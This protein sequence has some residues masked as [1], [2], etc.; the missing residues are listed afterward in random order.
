MTK[1]YR[2]PLILGLLFMIGLG[3]FVWVFKALTSGSEPVIL[4]ASARG[5]ELILNIPERI[6]VNEPFQLIIRV[7]T[8]NERV[9]AAGIYLSFDPHMLQVLQQ[10]TRSSF[11]Q[12]YP[13]K[14][15]DNR[16][17]TVSLAC[18]SPHPGFSGSNTLMILEFMPLKVG[19]SVIR[20]SQQ[21]QILKSDGKGTN[22]LSAYPMVEIKAGNTP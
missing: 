22:I 8:H 20:T 5:S 18:G 6:Q 15:Y 19:A 10:D 16:T 2:Q 7:D 13:E 21:S 4:A 12:F 9:N 11:C 17:G 14:K 1:L 3:S